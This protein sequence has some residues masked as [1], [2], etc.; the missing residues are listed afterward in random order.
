MEKI[1]LKSYP[2][3][4]PED[5]DLT[6]FASLREMLVSCCKQF[7]GKKAATNMGHSLTFDE[8]DALSRDF[9]AYL[10]SDLGL[11]RGDRLALMMP[12]CLQ[13]PIAVYGA[14]RVG[15]IIVNVNPMY[16]ARE[17]HH[18]MEDSGAK[19]I[20]VMENFA[21]TVQEVL[22]EVPLEAVITTQ[23]GDM[24]PFVKRTVTNFVLKRVKKLVPAFD[25][26]HTICFSDTLKKGSGLKVPD[27]E[28]NLDDVAFLQ[29]TGGTTGVAKGAVLT[30]GNIIANALQTAAWLSIAS[31]PGEE[32]L[33]TPL[34]LYHVF[35]LLAHSFCYLKLGGENVLITNPRDGEGMV[36]TMQNTNFT[37]ITAVNTL[38]NS[39][40]HTPGFDQCD[41]SR[42][43]VALGGGMAV[44][45]AVAEQW[46]KVTG[47]PIIEAYGLTETSPAACMNPMTNT[48][49]NG[50]IGLPISSTIVTIRDDA[51]KEVPIGEVGELCIQGPQVMREY[52]NRPD[53][54]AKV[55]LDDHCLKTGDVGRMDRNGFAYI[56][57]RKKD[58]ILVSGFNVYPNEV[59]SVAVEHPGVLEVAAVGIPHERSGEMVKLF[60]VKKDESLTEKALI[61][62]CR[63]DLSAYKVPK[64]V[65]FRESLPKSNVGKI[66]RRA[67]RE[68]AETPPKAD[69]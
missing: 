44:Q 31:K 4:V 21:H 54:T 5:I 46:K 43:R 52:W 63:K 8:I 27:E 61:D 66:L 29:Y 1:W 34:P 67:L 40:L 17:L 6:E 15:V 25:I 24:F 33:I 58:M 2:E 51:G 9:G 23:L 36:K 19:A 3:G 13:Y 48:E 64:R 37:G 11:K 50:S 68:E 30:H 42:M 32:V 22:P 18:Q 55:F 56:E 45:R 12:N 16:T 47:H 53:E 39:L 20:V 26:P 60:V 65:E 35:A 28:L 38:F 14:V 7:S 69:A 10:R 57:D 49:Y 41:F 62:H 59:E